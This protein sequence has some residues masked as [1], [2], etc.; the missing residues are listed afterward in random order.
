MKITRREANII[1]A[2]FYKADLHDE[3]SVQSVE[4][5]HIDGSTTIMEG[6]KRS[7]ARDQRSLRLR[8]K[9]AEKIRAAFPERS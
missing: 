4:V 1:L 6:Y 2:A 8:A 3:T 5:S 9:L 7:H